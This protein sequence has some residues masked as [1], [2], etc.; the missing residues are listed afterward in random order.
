MGTSLWQVDGVSGTLLC[1]LS[2]RPGHPYYL[3]V[4]RAGQPDPFLEQEYADRRSALE[5]SIALYRAFK[6]RGWTDVTVPDACSIVRT[7][8]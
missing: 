1:V 6:D 3:R 8:H 4:Y 5:V 2:S 7:T